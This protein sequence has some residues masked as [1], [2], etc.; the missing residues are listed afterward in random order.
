MKVKIDTRG[1]FHVITIQEREL[2]ANMT[3]D[4]EHLLL[5]YLQNDVKNIMLNMSM[6]N[7]VD[8][9]LAEAL[10]AIQQRFY[11]LQV[12]FVMCEMQPDVEHFFDQTGLLEMLNLTPTE[13]EAAD[14]IHMEEIERELDI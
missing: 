10:A 14:I 11:E 13:S 1:K 8:E 7:A 3:A 12:S 4:L 9:N 6:V 2:Y 5:P